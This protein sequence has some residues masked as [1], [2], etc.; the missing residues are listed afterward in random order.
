ITDVLVRRPKSLG[1]DAARL[2]QSRGNRRFCLDLGVGHKVLQSIMS[3]V[4]QQ[5]CADT[6]MTKLLTLAALVLLGNSPARATT[7]TTDV[8]C[9]RRDWPLPRPDSI[10]PLSC[11]S[12]RSAR[13]TTIVRSETPVATGRCDSRVCGGARS[14]RPQQRCVRFL[15]VRALPRTEP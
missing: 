15:P 2:N 7:R 13:S 9:Q 8:R 5:H 3:I 1:V 12:S 11:S 4:Q 6:E 14:R 10:W